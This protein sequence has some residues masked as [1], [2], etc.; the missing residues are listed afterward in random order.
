MQS[1]QMLNFKNTKKDL[2]FAGFLHFYMNIY[3]KNLV[4]L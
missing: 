1:S 4:F 3:I 2:S